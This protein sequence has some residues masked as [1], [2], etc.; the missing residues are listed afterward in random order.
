MT[1]SCSALAAVHHVDWHEQ[2]LQVDNIYKDKQRLVVRVCSALE[3]AAAPLAKT[4]HSRT[5]LQRPLAS[6]D[7]SRAVRHLA[8]EHSS[9][10]ERHLASDEETLGLVLH[11]Q[12]PSS[13]SSVSISL[14]E[15]LL[16]IF[17]TLFELK[18]PSVL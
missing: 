8:S 9:R 1:S 12:Q 7:S 18:H 4:G 11:H 10:A 17:C 5:W 2:Q 3:A 14:V 13:L 15:R 6:D 16:E